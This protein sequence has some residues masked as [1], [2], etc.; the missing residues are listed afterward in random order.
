MQITGGK[1]NSR[2][3]KTAEYDNIKPTLSKTRQGIFNT[4]ISMM[5]FEGKIFFDM[6]AGS[7]IMSLEAISRGFQVVSFEK[8]RKTA[9][10]IKEA[11]KSLNLKPDL[12]FG[13]VLKNIIKVNIK[14]DVIFIDPPYESDLYEQSLTIIKN[15]NILQP[16]GIIIMEH[17]IDKS[18]KI[19]GFKMIKVKTYGDKQI[20]YISQAE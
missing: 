3:I 5:D 12:Y 4:L 13:D 15:N 14:P 1:Y 20:T 2:K 10:A 6:F 16:N 11:F 8:D 7:G 17:P 19:E 18:I 9:I